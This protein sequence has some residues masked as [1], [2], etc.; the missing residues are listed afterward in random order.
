LLN[1]DSLVDVKDLEEAFTGEQ[2]YANAVFSYINTVSK[3]IAE[4]KI[5]EEKG[6]IDLYIG[7]AA[8]AELC[9]G[10]KPEQSAELQTR[11]SC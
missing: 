8:G 10:T 9:P 11:P 3:K 5:K 4:G 1:Y 7:K 2:V 6:K